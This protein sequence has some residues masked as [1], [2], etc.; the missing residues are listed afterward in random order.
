MEPNLQSAME[1]QLKFLREISDRLAAQEVR[2]HGRESTVAH[3]SASIH[4]TKVVAATAPSTNLSAEL[5]AQV[6]ATHEW[7]G[8]VADDR[9]SLRQRRRLR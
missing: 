3:H 2:W 9:G 6:V 7:L 8:V 1:E 4:D 5:D